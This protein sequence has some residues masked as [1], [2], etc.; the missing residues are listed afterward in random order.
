MSFD[1]RQSTVG[2]LLNDAI[3][4]I[5]RNQR[6]YVWD[7]QN[8]N[9]L[10]QDIKLV[11]SGVSSSHFIGSI[12]LMEE[13][14]EEGLS[15]FTIIDGQQRI[16]TLT[17]LLSSILY[18]FKRRGLLEDAGGTKK[19]LVATDVKSNEHA[20][21]SPGNHLT[22][23]RIV[24]GVIEV[25]GK[26][27]SSMT[28]SAFAKSK[29]VSMSKD[30][31]IVKAFQHFSTSIE[32]MSDDV[33]IAFRDAVISTS[34][35]NIS[36]STEEDSYTIFEILN[37]R[38]MELEDHEL[39]KNY[40]MRYINPA[41]K[42]DD[43]KAV[44][45]EIEQLLGSNMKPFL[46]HYAIQRYRLAQKDKEGPYKKIRDFADPAKASD[47]LFDLKKKAEYYAE[48]LAPTTND[49]SAEILLFLKAHNVRV[50]RPLLM[51]LMH[52]RDREQ[53]SSQEY[54]DSL[55][56]IYKFYICYKVVGGMES[57]H[58]TDSIVKHSYSLETNYSPEAVEEWRSSFRKKLPSIEAF[59]TSLGALGW[60]HQW[61][62]Y[63]DNKLKERCKL[64]LSLLEQSMGGAKESGDYTIEH[65]LPDSESE[66]NA[67]IGNLL[68]L[69]AALNT[70]CKNRP[71]DEKLPIY[72]E[73]RFVST[74]KFAERYEKKELDIVRR[75]G[76]MAD[77]LYKQFQMQ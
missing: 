30:S 21:V 35:V 25:G 54:C 19:Y 15:V 28:P 29:C 17:I 34:Y 73:S 2:K 43:A 14:A 49:R 22:L 32:S 11:T 59:K 64:V 7:E 1:A 62:L 60:S 3:Y 33:L 63:E 77:V 65:V 57:N 53:I 38:G 4:R 50:F 75:A 37:A 51:S 26:D 48:I 18:A 56:F 68:P 69:E 40:I 44:W 36:S 55:E 8:W 46:R 74:R 12:V 27:A 58:L 61:S 6:M 41:E 16:I 10:F 71:L 9:D 67:L 5:P 66:H 13:T 76:Y 23:E 70:R 20:I 42:R 52:C 47:L 24:R 45:S 39:L 31:L 72:R